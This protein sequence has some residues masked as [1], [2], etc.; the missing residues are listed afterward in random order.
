MKHR[1]SRPTDPRTRERLLDLAEEASLYLRRHG[2][3]SVR[4]AAALLL[5]SSLAAC[6]PSEPVEQEESTVTPL[7]SEVREGLPTA[8]G[9]YPV[10]PASVGRNE[11]GVY[12]LAWRTPD[13]TSWKEARISLL[14]LAEGSQDLLEIPS[15]GDPVLWLT[16]DTPVALIEGSGS[17]GAA[18]EASPE[19][20]PSPTAAVASSNTTS[21]TSRTSS[22]YSSRYHNSV[23][24]YPFP[25]IAGTSGSTAS[26]GSTTS[27][28]SS[29]S[30]GTVASSTPAYRNPPTAAP[31]QGS[32]RGSSSSLVA[33]STSA[34]T[35]SSSG[36]TSGQA[37]GSGSGTAASSRSGV[38]TSSGPSQGAA[39]PSSSGFT[40]GRSGST[41][42][43]TAG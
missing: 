33:P 39:R 3:P 4:V 23:A 20:S 28:S 8:P 24:W 1:S 18:A 35:W 29:P 19:A 32:V 41:G 13:G 37:G 14:R 25:V 5:A 15:S 12:A 27:S 38:N 11:Q 16:A 21:S 31:G 26:S 2:E 43:S 40:G 17:A 42:G 34:R 10:D 9:R 6:S 22:G 30:N 36:R 7:E